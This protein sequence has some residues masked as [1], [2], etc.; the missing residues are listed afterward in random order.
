MLLVYNYWIANRC[1]NIALY[2]IIASAHS[3]LCAF[4]STKETFLL[5]AREVGNDDNEA[6]EARRQH[7][8]TTLAQQIVLIWSP[9]SSKYVSNSRAI[10][11]VVVHGMPNLKIQLWSWSMILP[12][13]FGSILTKFIIATILTLGQLVHVLL[14][15]LSVLYSRILVELLTLPQTMMVMLKEAG[16]SCSYEKKKKKA[17]PIKQRIA[18]YKTLAGA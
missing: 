16:E 15:M 3:L 4:F 14:Q 6:W 7:S 9:L 8:I 1:I 10:C 2:L 11:H 17:V 18:M 13:T 5:G 12:S